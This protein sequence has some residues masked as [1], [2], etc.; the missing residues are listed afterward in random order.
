MTR[1]LL[2]F[3]IVPAF[4]SAQVPKEHRKANTMIIE[5]EESGEDLLMKIGRHLVDKDYE[6]D[7]LDKDFLTMTTKPR[8]VKNV[9]NTYIRV[10]VSGNKAEFQ[11]YTSMDLDLGVR[12]A[13]YDLS[14]F[15]G[16][17]G[18]PGRVASDN[19]FK[20]VNELNDNIQ[21]AQK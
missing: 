21:Y 15:R 14:N 13:G 10:K 2:L 5:T 1:L 9:L 4:L 6:I 3:L 17:G 7:N 12:T 16:Q 18:S 20:I 19:L 8:L 11:N